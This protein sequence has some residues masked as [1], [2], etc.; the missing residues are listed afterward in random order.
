MRTLLT[1]LTLVAL[2]TG[3]S[4]HDHDYDGR[5]DCGPTYRRDY[6][7]HDRHGHHDRDRHHR[8]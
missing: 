2:M 3:C 8:Y 6:P 7:H 1:L 4:Y 5:E